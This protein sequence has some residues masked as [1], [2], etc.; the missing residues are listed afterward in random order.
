MKKDPFHRCCFYQ[1]FLYCANKKFRDNFDP[2]EKLA[3]VKSAEGLF[4]LRSSIYSIVLLGQR[5][6][7]R[8]SF[9]I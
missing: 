3:S 8:V 6:N 7:K 1:V 4:L 9:V 2:N 5:K